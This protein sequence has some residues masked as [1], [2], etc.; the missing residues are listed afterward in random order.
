MPG[1]IPRGRGHGGEEGGHNHQARVVMETVA[2]L[3]PP[4]FVGCTGKLNKGD[5]L[6]YFQVLSAF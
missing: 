1:S 3:A 6:Y 4:D 5:H 2:T